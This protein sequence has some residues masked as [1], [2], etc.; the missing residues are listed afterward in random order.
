MSLQDRPLVNPRQAPTRVRLFELARQA[1]QDTEVLRDILWQITAHCH[2]I[3]L[4]KAMSMLLEILKLAPNSWHETIERLGMLRW[5]PVLQWVSHNGQMLGLDLADQEFNQ[6]ETASGRN[7][8]M[9]SGV[10]EF[11]LYTSL[12]ESLPPAI[13]RDK[14]VLLVGELTLAHIHAVQQETQR[15]DYED[16]ARGLEWKLL[17]N[18]LNVAALAVRRLNE[19]GNLK[20]LQYLPV[21]LSP[22]DFA[23]ELEQL[24][25]QLNADYPDDRKHL[26]RFLQKAWNI[27][28]WVEKGQGAAG[29]GSSGGHAWVGGRWEIGDNLTVASQPI[30]DDL[31]Q[32]NAWG[33]LHI[34]KRQTLNAKQRQARL[35]SDL[36]P[37]EDEEE[38]EIVLSDFDCDTSRRDIGTLVRIARAKARHV[39]LSNQLV[40]WAYAGLATQE[41]ANIVKQV[42]QDFNQKRAE[43]NPQNRLDIEGVP[44]F[45]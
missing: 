39:A 41:I 9:E 23:I 35:Q 40:P 13:Y 28:D 44:N 17:P 2:L 18:A 8:I 24:H 34:A 30:G 1:G 7:P 29:G 42:T 16:D 5:Q 15:S 19:A 20:F 6:M 45:V 26:Y 12:C 21:H 4:P 11:P 31:D 22:V 3:A 38:Q 10:P 37:D 43:Q 32:A 25:Q 27:I 36:S 14:F 33:E